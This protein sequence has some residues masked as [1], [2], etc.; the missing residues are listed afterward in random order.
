MNLLQKKNQMNLPRENAEEDA[1][2]AET[3]QGETY[4]LMNIPYDD[5]YKAELKNNDVK[6]DAFTSATLN[7]LIISRNDENGK[8]CL[9]CKSGRI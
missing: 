8:F 7:K 6:V 2:S 1:F 3:Q 9:S 4:V 5:F